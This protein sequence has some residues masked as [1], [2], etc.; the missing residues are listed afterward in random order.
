MNI[1]NAQDSI[2]HYIFTSDV[3]F[4]L[5]KEKFRNNSNVSAKEVNNAMA[6]AMNHLPE[7]VL[8]ND[9]LVGSNKKI[10]YVEGLIITGD[11][12]NRQESGVQPAS[13]SWKDFQ[14]VY[15]N[16]L[17]LKKNSKLNTDLF[18]MAGNH[19]V[20]NTIGYHKEM[21]PLTDA[22]S[23]VG[24]YNL[25]M[26]PSVPKTTETINYAKDKIHYSKDIDG[27]H[28]LFINLWPDSTERAW[29]ENDLKK[30][31]AT[32]PVL[33]FTH[34]NPDVEARFF[35]NPNGNH[36]INAEDHFENLLSE[37]FKDG[38]SVTDAA[39]IEQKAFAAFIKHHPNIKG[40]FHGHNAQQTEYYTWSGPD[41]DIQLP[42]FRVDSPMKGKLSAKDETQLSFEFISID[43][44]KKLLTVRECLW[45]KTKSD[46][47]EQPIT[48]GIATTI[49][50]K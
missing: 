32:T 25:M 5:T 24:I 27:V 17:K 50:L 34:S 21:Q 26:K 43:S 6:L 13:Q 41:K 11:I 1:C 47:T 39:V 7:I 40:Y 44:A 23:Y 33:I 19:D 14:N 18:L 22:T 31:A 48:W 2:K 20:S 45:N 16:N 36:S 37:T 8:P 49:S 42:C 28:F 3:H 35:V 12:A 29:M 4:G 10:K 30:I 15:I 38:K 9:G 46:N